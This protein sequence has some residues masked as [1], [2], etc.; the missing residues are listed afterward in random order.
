MRRL[1]N[2]DDW[3]ATERQIATITG[4]S[5]LQ[6]VED[7][8]GRLWLFW[9]YADAIWASRRG[10][11]DMWTSPVQVSVGSQIIPKLAVLRDYL[12]DIWLFWAAGDQ[13]ASAPRIFNQRYR[14]AVDQWDS[15]A[16]FTDSPPL[17]F[18]PAVIEHNR[19]LWV[20]W[21]HSPILPPDGGLPSGPRSPM[22]L[23]LYIRKFLPDV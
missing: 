14:I 13:G 16:R 23:Q 21:W 19:A 7:G 6:A 2:T 4:A 8:K 5:S 9:I 22:S 17:H 1:N 15:P 3:E 12:G 18:T 20:F 10:T 11:D